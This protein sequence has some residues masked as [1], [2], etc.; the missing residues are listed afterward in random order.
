VAAMVAAS[1][2]VLVAEL[3]AESVEAMGRG[4]VAT[5]VAASVVVLVADLVA[6]NTVVM[7]NFLAAQTEALLLSLSLSI[8][9]MKSAFL[10]F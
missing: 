7:E 3:V 4:S 10:Q 5:M 1:V 8:Y 6:A 2:V 9:S